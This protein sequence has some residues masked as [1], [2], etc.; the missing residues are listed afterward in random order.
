MSIAAPQ[1]LHQAA[2]QEPVTRP[3]R[4]RRRILR[5]LIG[6]LMAA[7]AVTWIGLRIQP[8]PLPPVDL[9]PADVATTGLPDDLP[10]PVA[11]FYQAVYG[12]AVPVVRTAVISGRGTMRI[13]G[14]TFPA[15]FRFSHVAG[16]DYRHYIE[17]TVFGAKMLAVDEWFVDGKARL[18]LPF[19]VSE[20]PNIDQG[21][22]LALWAEAI[23]MPSL[24]VTD[25][26][27][28]W[29]PIDDSSA[30]LVVPFGSQQ[31][32]FTVTFD[33]DTGL[34]RRME[35]MRYRGEGDAAKTLW[36][37]EV[38]QWGELDGHT[39]PLH[40]TVAWGDERPW[41]RLRAEELVYNA[42]LSSYVRAAGP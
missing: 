23:W 33:P 2:G 35:S 42:D 12:D 19:G 29:E 38:V 1:E 25:E 10:A 6:G 37:N 8:Q 27:T 3:P 9:T 18:Q 41:A 24:W 16:Q 15:R 7:V 5:Y 31:E 30:R 11:R 40:A 4:R 32:T 22:N 13:S 26:R 21:A 14:I 17:N 20:G 28:R 36:V 34:L 39:V